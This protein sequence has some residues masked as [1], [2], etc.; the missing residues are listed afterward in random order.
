[1]NIATANRFLAYLLRV[2]CV[3]LALAATSAWAS[4]V[5]WDL[6]PDN[7]NP[8]SQADIESARGP[9]PQVPAAPISGSISFFGSSMAS[10][11][12]GQGTTTISFGDNW[13]SVAGIGTYSSIPFMTPAAFNNFSFT[14]DGTSVSLT[15]PVVSLWSLAFAGHSYSFDLL[16]LTNGHVDQG[17]MAFTGTGLLHATGFDDTLGSFGMTGSGNDFM[18]TLSF[19]TVSAVP[20]ATSLVPAALLALSAI[21]LEICRRRRAA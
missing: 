3:A 20:E 19:V 14:G 1:M 7:F 4:F 21:L 16:S 6:N 18:Y 10:G 11:P 13:A 9:L 5:P 12:S 17:S 8:A 2:F 15:A